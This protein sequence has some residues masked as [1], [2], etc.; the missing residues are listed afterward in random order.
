MI[1]LLFYDLVSFV[2]VVFLMV[3]NVFVEGSAFPVPE[4]NYKSETHD[5]LIIAN[6][7]HLQQE[8]VSQVAS[9]TD[10]RKNAKD[11]L[12][13]QYQRLDRLGLVGTIPAKNR[14]SSICGTEEKGGIRVNTVAKEVKNESKA[15]YEQSSSAYTESATTD[16]GPIQ[17]TSLEVMVCER[18]KG[19]KTEE[20]LEEVTASNG[21]FD[22]LFQKYVNT[23]HVAT[24]TNEKEGLE[25]ELSSFSSTY[26]Y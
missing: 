20:K 9:T 8:N 1:V 26:N 4:S 2:A 23:L 22:E 15:E 10:L 14:E 21:I 17:V 25:R 18:L 12:S 5:P 24:K 6:G 19:Y 13:M 11:D 7:S 3:L 16:V